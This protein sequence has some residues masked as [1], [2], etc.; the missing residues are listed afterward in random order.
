MGKII[1]LVSQ[2]HKLAGP[3]LT[4]LYPLYASVLAMESTTKKDDEQWLS[5]WI[6]YSFI[7]LVEMVMQPALELFP[8]WYDVKLVLMAW[9]V[10]P[11]FKGAKFLYKR[12]VREH[13]KKYT[14]KHKGEL[15]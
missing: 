15:H 4:L 2:L 10:L 14:G 9:L 6:L 8:V 3:C 13:I 1:F 12:F 7:T 11:K 5:Y